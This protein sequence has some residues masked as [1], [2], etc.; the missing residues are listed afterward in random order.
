MISTV[1]KG[2]V[3]AR[4][5]LLGS[6]ALGLAC[7]TA[8]ATVASN[9][10]QVS[11]TVA[12]T[13]LISPNNL[14]FG[15][16]SGVQVE[17]TTTISVTC[18]N[19]TTYNV[20]LDPGQASGATVTTRQMQNGSNLLSYALYSDAGYSTNWGQTVSTDTVAGTGNGSAQTLTVYGK[21]PAAQYVTPGSY[22]DTVTAT[23][24]Y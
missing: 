20:G 14:G 16:Y 15:T 8:M 2:L 7:S 17:T 21:I 5:G 3:L 10:F 23:V 1:R 18:T 4:M 11:A 9:T 24:T 6:A 12:A 22:S 19:T 13:C